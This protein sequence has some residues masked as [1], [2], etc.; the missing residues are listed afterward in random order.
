MINLSIV[1]LTHNQKEKTIRCLNSII[2]LTYD[3]NIEII[4]VDN[5]SSDGSR[6]SIISLFPKIKYIYNSKNF[7]VARGRNIGLKKAIGNYLMILDNDTIAT[8]EAI[9]SLLKLLSNNPEWGL[10]APLLLSPKGKIQKSIKEYPSILIKAKNWLKGRNED[11]FLTKSPTEPIE[12][13]YVIGA[14]QMFS[15]EI[16]NFV[17]GLDE[18][19]FY[20]PED[21]DFCIRVRNAGKKVVFLP[22][23]SIIHEWNRSTTRKLNKQTFLHIKGL[24]YFYWKYKRLW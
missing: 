3:P 4:I 17:G 7:G 13:F 6:D 2:G 9:Y 20:G 19:I 1:I 10:V 21:V 14:A 15:K 22:S 8:E 11:E 18:K 24:L 23:I 12:P 16:Y 5:G